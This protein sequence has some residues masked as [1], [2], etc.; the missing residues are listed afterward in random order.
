[1]AQHDI[2]SKAL[3]DATEF[4]EPK[5][6]RIGPEDH[7]KLLASMRQKPHAFAGNPFEEF[8]GVPL[9]KEREISGCYVE[10]EWRHPSVSITGQTEVVP[11]AL[12]VMNDT[13]RTALK[14]W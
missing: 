14:A 4:G 6:I 7:R 2:L 5:R 11:E 9:S 12:V 10:L 3:Y 8:E 1:M 13:R